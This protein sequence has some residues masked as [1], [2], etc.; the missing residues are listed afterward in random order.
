[1]FPVFLLF[2]EPLDNYHNEKGHYIKDTK[3]V[4]SREIYGEYGETA[5]RLKKGKRVRFI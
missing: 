1:M 4:R 2:L 3:I 5:Y